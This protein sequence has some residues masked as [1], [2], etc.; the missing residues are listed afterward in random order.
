MYKDKSME[1]I[2]H[3]LKKY[4]FVRE[5]KIKLLIKTKQTQKEL[6]NDDLASLYIHIPLILHQL[7]YSSYISSFLSIHRILFIK[8]TIWIININSISINICTID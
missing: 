2:I 4:Y 7:V 6:I 1:E 3:I 5:D 8:I